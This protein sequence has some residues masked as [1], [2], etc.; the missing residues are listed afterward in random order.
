MT[1]KFNLFIFGKNSFDA[2][3][4]ERKTYA[5]KEWWESKL[6]VENND[7]IFK[8]LRVLDMLVTSD[9]GER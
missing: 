2:F 4:R 7:T 1:Y 8:K 9:K 6:E 3:Q 5:K